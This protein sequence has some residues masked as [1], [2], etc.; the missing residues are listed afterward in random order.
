MT[1][2]IYAE[3]LREQ[4][5]KAVDLNEMLKFL[6]DFKE[7][8]FYEYTAKGFHTAEQKIREELS[9]ATAKY[10]YYKHAIEKIEETEKS[11]KE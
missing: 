2:L 8:D 5:G 1:K 6:N 11:L 7:K 9:V 4:Y 10:E 3:K